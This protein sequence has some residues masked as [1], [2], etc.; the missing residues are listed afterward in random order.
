MKGKMAHRHTFQK[1][2]HFTSAKRKT[3]ID[4]STAVKMFLHITFFIFFSL[5]RE[6]V[7]LDEHPTNN[8][9]AFQEQTYL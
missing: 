6:L 3:A 2:K 5:I 1:Q 9:F 8:L 7:T 4:S